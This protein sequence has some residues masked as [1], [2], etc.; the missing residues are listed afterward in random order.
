MPVDLCPSGK[1]KKPKSA[2][3]TWAF[4]TVSSAET[5]GAGDRIPEPLALNVH[6]ARADAVGIPGAVPEVTVVAIPDTAVVVPPDNKVAV[7]DPID[8][9]VAVDVDV[10]VD[11]NVAVDV[12]VAIDVDGLVDVDVLVDR[13]GVGRRRSRECE[14]KR[15]NG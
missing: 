8:A 3:L 4:L 15:R 6:P 14:S 10:P 12:D 11:M 2:V 7:A 5:S 9:H 1:Q 13:L